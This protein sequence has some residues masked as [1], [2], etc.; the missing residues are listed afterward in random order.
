[1]TKDAR[2]PDKGAQP[3]TLR[4]R[5][6]EKGTASN[7]FPEDARTYDPTAGAP[8]D[9]AG[10]HYAETVTSPGANPSSTSLPDPSPFKLGPQ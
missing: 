2:G 8:E 6:L 10:G 5:A 4:G 9:V 3:R 7:G 1:M